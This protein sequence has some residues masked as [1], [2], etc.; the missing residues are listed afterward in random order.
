MAHALAD[1]VRQKGYPVGRPRRTTADH[2]AA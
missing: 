1:A 2:D